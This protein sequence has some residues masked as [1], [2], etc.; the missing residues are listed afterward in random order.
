MFVG[1][2]GFICVCMARRLSLFLGGAIAPLL[3]TIPLAATP[4]DPTGVIFSQVQASTLTVDWQGTTGTTIQFTIELSSTAFVTPLSSTTA[5]LSSTFT[6]L[7]VNT[8]YF[9]RVIAIDT[10]DSSSSSWTASVSTYTMA[11]TPSALA[12]TLVSATAVDLTW[13]R[14]GNPSSTVFVVERSSGGVVYTVVGSI[15][16]TVYSDNSISPGVTYSYQVTALNN[17]NVSSGYSNVVL[18]SIPGSG[19]QPRTPTGFFLTRSQ[20]GPSAFQVDFQWHAVSE[21]EDGSVLS[22][23]AGYKIYTSTSLLTPRSQWVN[24]STPTTESWSTTTDGSVSYYALRT[25]DAD[26]QVSDWSRVVDDSSDLNHFFLA[27]DNIS[28]V[29]LPQSSANILRRGQ[30]AYGS[31]LELTLTQVTAEETGRVAKSLQIQLIN[32]DTGDEITK[33]SFQLPVIRGTLA[34]SVVGGVVVQGAPAHS[35]MRI[36]LVSSAQAA[37]ELSLFWFNGNEWVKTT[38]VINTTDNTVSFTATRIGRFQIR[39]ASHITGVSLTRVYPRIISPNQD[40][41]NDKVIFEFDNPTLAPLS[42]KIYDLNDAFVAELSAGPSTGSTLLWDGKDAGGKVVPGG[43]Y[44]Y[45]MGVGAE[46][47]SGTVVVAR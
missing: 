46:A 33:P 27:E 28:R 12:T 1:N 47:A 45:Q 18:A 11:A 20:T 36:P 16:N 24:I 7:D 44:L 15:A 9:A 29:Q 19:T 6:G 37:E 5:V 21:R 32:Y 42:G 34:Y 31:D 2:S 4:L 26:G 39:A 14:N 17:A 38:A 8:L 13:S 22:N 25:V 35:L 41:W 43:I 10:V 30:N 23:L 40:G 3:L